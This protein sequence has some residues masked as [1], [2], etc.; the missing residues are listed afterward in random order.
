M[1]RLFY[2]LNFSFLIF[3][4][5]ACYT[6]RYVYSPAAHNVPVLVQEGDSKI[7]FNLSTNFTGDKTVNGQKQKNKGN[8]FDL[9][10]AYAVTNNFA[11]QAAF[12]R[13]TETN[14]GDF[15]SNLDSSIIN[16]KRNLTEFGIG[17]YKDLGNSRQAIF[18]VFAGVG[19][20]KSGFKDRGKDRNNVFY[21]RFH[22]MNV[23]KVYVQPAFM[24]RSKKNFAA[25]LSSRFSVI[26]FQKIKT[27]Y[28]AI[29]L[30]NYKLDSLGYPRLFWEPAMVN[31]FGFKK[32]PGLQFEFQM[33]LALLQS[34]RFVDYRSF[35]LSTGILFDLTK[36]LKVKTPASKN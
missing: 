27:D 4:W 35:N 18:Q 31:T 12:I 23:T 32:L 20:G 25:A 9:Q 24:I 10:G 28:T 36:L 13:R 14:N 29:E 22:Q 8:G 15:V 7:A 3:N 11:V 21:N 6:P 33:G 1:K 30:D 2:I 17:Y 26:Y 19:F 16:Y 34:R 5:C